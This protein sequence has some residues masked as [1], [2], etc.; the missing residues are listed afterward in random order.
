MDTTNKMTSLVSPHLISGDHTLNSGNGL[1][2]QIGPGRFLET[3]ELRCWHFSMK[4]LCSPKAS[5]HPTVENPLLT[6]K[7]KMA[8]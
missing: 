5:S 7:L 1:C 3:S 8:K 6:L 2:K 4:R